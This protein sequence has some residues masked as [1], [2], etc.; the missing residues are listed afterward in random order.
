MS[1][2]VDNALLR[3]TIE[4][5]NKD[6]NLNYW[7]LL[8]PLL[9]GIFNIE[10]GILVSLIYIC[11]LIIELKRVTQSNAAAQLLIMNAQLTK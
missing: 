10:W 8:I 7:L 2:G 6:A 1:E 4:T 9:I 11:Y 3:E 5:Y